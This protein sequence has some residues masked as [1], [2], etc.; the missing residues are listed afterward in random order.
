MPGD[1]T[2]LIRSWF[3][4]HDG[5][6]EFATGMRAAPY[7]VIGPVGA[8]GRVVFTTKPHSASAILNESETS[9]SVGM[10]GRYGLPDKA[11]LVW[12]RTVVGR[13]V[14]LFLG[15]MD[16]VDLLVFAW[17]RA[18]LGQKRVV[19]L[20]VSD[21]LLEAIQF[22]PNSSLCIRCASSERKSLAL[23]NQVLPGFREIVGPR[24]AAMLD[25]GANS[26]S[27]QR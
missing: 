23:L 4:K 14:L 11:D 21:S 26:S 3:A 1:A 12:I 5:D 16:P 20:G 25:Q 13:R 24:C 8:A 6:G 7:S 17:L 18:S 15:D 2:K 22:E 27:K 9:K 10:I 19:H